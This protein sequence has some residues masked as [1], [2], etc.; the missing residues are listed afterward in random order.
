MCSVRLLLFIHGVAC[1]C[2]SLGSFLLLG[3]P[4]C[5]YATVC[6]SGHLL[7]D[8]WAAFSFGLLGISCYEH[9][10]KSF[11]G[12]LLAFL[13][14]NTQQW[15]CWG[16]GRSN[17]FHPLSGCCS[18]VG[19]G[20]PSLSRG[21]ALYLSRGEAPRGYWTCSGSQRNPSSYPMIFESFHI[22]IHK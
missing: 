10:C 12:S 9:T 17:Y 7:V 22:L 20:F 11:G 14:I 3:S 4:S 8:T 19:V 18:P 5:G 13:S 21:E 16:T 15:N 2:S 6:L 1:V